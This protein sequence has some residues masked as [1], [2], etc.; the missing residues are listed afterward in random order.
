GY[1]P[2]F[3]IRFPQLSDDQHAIVTVSGE[4][5]AEIVEYAHAYVEAAQAAATN[6]LFGY[7]AKEREARQ[8]GIEN[9]I[10]AA[11]SVANQQRLDRIRELEQALAVA[12]HQNISTLADG[13]ALRAA[14]G[15]T[16]QADSPTDV[17]TYLLGEAAIRA[18]LQHLQLRG[19]DDAYVAELPALMRRGSALSD[20]RLDKSGF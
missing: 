20:V 4:D 3:G 13:A 19:N 1:D 12:Q 5:P 11:R 8:Q 9:E 10:S 15:A 17:P 2:A 7:L 18:E 14:N 16:D 6:E